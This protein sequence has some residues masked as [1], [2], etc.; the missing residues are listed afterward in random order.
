MTWSKNWSNEILLLVLISQKWAFEVRHCRKK[1]FCPIT[2]PEV[3]KLQNVGTHPKQQILQVLIAKKAGSLEN[4]IR[5]FMWA[6]F[7]DNWFSRKLVIK[8]WGEKS[9]P[10]EFN[11]I[12]SVTFMTLNIRPATFKFFHGL[13]QPTVI[14]FWRI[15]RSEESE[16]TEFLFRPKVAKLTKKRNTAIWPRLSILLLHGV[17][18][19]Q[20][21]QNWAFNVA[22]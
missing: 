21:A 15:N 20:K 5:F 14:F 6:I 11:L 2:V 4:Q 22:I 7:V 18:K 12:F 1:P 10:S 9:K 19:Q 13:V 17:E 16:L 8:C 3:E